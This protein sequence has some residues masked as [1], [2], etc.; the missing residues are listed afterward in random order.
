MSL[1][2]CIG[3]KRCHSGRVAVLGLADDRNMDPLVCIPPRVLCADATRVVHSAFHACSLY[4][5]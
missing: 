4:V 1:S 2:I 3:L 5:R